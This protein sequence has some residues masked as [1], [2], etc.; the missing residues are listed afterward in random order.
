MSAP[1]NDPLAKEHADLRRQARAARRDPVA[2]TLGVVVMQAVV[3][4]EGLRA[5]GAAP[6]QVSAALETVVRDAWPKGRTEPWRDLCAECR[7]YGWKV[8]EC[9][10]DA[11]CGRH[12]AHLAHAYAVAC[13][14]ERGRVVMPKV[15]QQHDELASVGKMPK[16]PARWG[17]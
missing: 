13:W 7:D 15:K 12:K 14:C 10:G 5:Q 3:E 2:S 11:T 16:G 1:Y 9:P 6:E 17:R 8:V 4:A